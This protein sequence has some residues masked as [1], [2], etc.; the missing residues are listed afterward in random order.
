M[1]TFSVVSRVLTDNKMVWWRGG[2][3]DMV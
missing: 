3:D 1:S 2:F